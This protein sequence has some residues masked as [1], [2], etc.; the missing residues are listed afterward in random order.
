MRTFFA[1]LL[2]ALVSANS[3]GLVSLNPDNFKTY[4]NS[5]KTLLV[6]FFAPWCG[7]CKRLAPTY[8]EVAQAFAENEDVIIAEVNCDDH[9][10][11]CQEHGIRGFP[12]V[13]VFN[14]EESKKFQEQRTVEELKKFV[15]ENVPAKN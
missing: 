10:E 4:Q 2:V 11:L 1:L 9:R 5:G 12:T 15:L 7:H 13:L 3:E 6:K 14:G 8:E